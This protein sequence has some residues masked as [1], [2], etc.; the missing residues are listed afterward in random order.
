MRQARVAVLGAL[1]G[2]GSGCNEPRPVDISGAWTGTM[3]DATGTRAVEAQFTQRGLHVDGLG[4]ASRSG[5]AAASSRWIGTIVDGPV[6]SFSLAI[7][8]PPCAI[9]IAGSADVA[10]PA[11]E[12]TYVGRDDCGTAAWG[13]GRMTLRRR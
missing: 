9:S 8:D 6:F 13:D 7:T 2:A 1:L 12:A 3:T 11:F 4:T 10:E 5:G